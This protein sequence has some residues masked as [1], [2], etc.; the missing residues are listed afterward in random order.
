M[1]QIFSK[2]LL[3]RPQDLNHAGTLFGGV[4]MSLA[5][6]MAF[7]AATLSF[8][9][10]T[11]VTKVFCEFNFISSVREGDIVRIEAEVI[12]R[13]RSSL[14]V[15]VRA[16]NAATGSEIFQTEAVLVNARNGR[17]IP[18]NDKEVSPPA[19]P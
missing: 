19:S 8:P 3:V 13:G 10:C 16:S 15:S 1:A 2:Y 6:E 11:F 9:G 12:S 4:M 17:S 5:D 18:I 7:I 14:R